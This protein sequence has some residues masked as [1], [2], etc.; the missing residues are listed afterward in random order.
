MQQGIPSATA[1]FVANLRA[2]HQ[3]VD[4]NPKILLDPVAVPLSTAA[5]GSSIDTAA[6]QVQT[7]IIN[8][9]RSL[10]VMRSRFVEDQLARAYEKGTRQYAILG[11]GLDTFPYR[12][13]SFSDELLIFEID[14][15]ATQIWKRQLLAQAGIP[16]PNNLRFVP[17]DFESTSLH[18]ALSRA[19]FARNVPSLFS[20]LGVVQYLT[21]AA[22]QTTLQYVAGL[23]P[24]TEIALTFVLPDEDLS[25]IDLEVTRFSAAFA[26]NRGEPWITRFRPRALAN[27]LLSLGFSST[28]HFSADD[29]DREYFGSRSDGLLAPRWEELLVATV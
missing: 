7:P 26:A 29:A 10:F 28:S 2:V 24:S 17:I 1:K 12:Q 11:A 16:L 13:P 27:L 8:A 15:P 19:G 9:L 20:W 3:L 4:D 14:H 25:G 5:L 18:D 22:T 21:W 23:E 6:D